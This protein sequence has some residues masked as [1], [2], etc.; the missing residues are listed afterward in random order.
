MKTQPG[1]WQHL[2]KHSGKGLPAAKAHQGDNWAIQAEN[3]AKAKKLA[4]VRKAKGFARH[5]Q[6]LRTLKQLSVI[7][8][9]ARWTDEHG[10]RHSIW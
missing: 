3:Q 4:A 6:A 9:K 10:V 8:P 5:R 1:S 2:G 7:T